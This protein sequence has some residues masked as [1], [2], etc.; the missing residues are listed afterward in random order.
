MSEDGL[1]EEAEDNNIDDSVEEISEAQI[2]QLSSL[3]AAVAEE[4]KEALELYEAIIDAI[5][6]YLTSSEPRAEDHKLIQNSALTAAIDLADLG[7]TLDDLD[8]SGI[9]FIDHNDPRAGR[10][11]GRVL[12]DSFTLVLAAR[13]R[14]DFYELNLADPMDLKDWASQTDLGEWF[15]YHLLPPEN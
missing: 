3:A 13:Q 5:V 14:E 4:L 6:D 15:D 11:F 8:Q 2:A 10:E 12:A 9:P 7:R 1:K